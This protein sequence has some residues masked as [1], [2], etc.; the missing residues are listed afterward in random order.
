MKKPG[1]KASGRSVVSRMLDLDYLLTALTLVSMT[2]VAVV[3]VFYRFVLNDPLLWSDELVKLLF[4]WFCFAGMSVVA[5]T[6]AHLRMD[7]L[8]RL[9]GAR[10]TLTLRL[11]S[12]AI[13]LAVL[14]ILAV[15]GIKLSIAQV[16]NQF[17]SLPI[18]RAWSFAA[19]PFGAGLMTCRLIPLMAS[20]FHDLLATP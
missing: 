7:I 15:S 14:V 3:A 20:D 5:Q 9:F 11:M 18:S 4:T 8:D 10:P 2:F 1:R 6:S 16:S 12:N 13:V 19:L 17:A